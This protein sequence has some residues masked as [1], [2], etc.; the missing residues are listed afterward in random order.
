MSTI[1][2]IVTSGVTLGTITS[3]STYASPLTITSTGGVEVASGTAIYGDS[4]TAWNLV[5]YGTVSVAGS[6]GIGIVFAGSGTIANGIGGHTTALIVGGAGTYRSGVGYLGGPGGIGIFLEAGGS[7]DN[8]GTIAGGYGGTGGI[9]ENGGSGGVAIDVIGAVGEIVNSGRITGGRGGNGGSDSSG[10]GGN[11]ALGGTGIILATGGINNSASISGGAGGTGGGGFIGG[12]GG[13]GGVG[14]DLTGFGTVTNSGTISGGAFGLGG[15]GLANGTAGV[16]GTGVVLA[17]GGTVIDSGA[18][19]GGVTALYF[20]GAGGNLL[21]LEHGYSFGGAVVASGTANTLALLGTAG[22]AV[23]VLY[24]NFQA[25]NFQNVLFG[26]GG[27]AT[28]DVTNTTGTLGVTI[29]GFISNTETIDLTGLAAGTLANGGTAS[30]GQLVVSNGVQTLTL[31]LGAG[32]ATVFAAGSDG[33]VGTDIT[34]ACFLRGTLIETP[35][36]EVAVE[37]LRIGDLLTTLSGEAR[38]IRWIGHRAYDGRFIAGNRQVLPVCVKAGALAEGVPARELWLS[39]EHSL[40]VAGALAQVKH[41]VNGMTIVQADA[42]ERVEYF[43]IELDEH[44]LIVADGAP[45]ETFV[46][47][48]NRLMFENGAEY[49]ALYPD[50]ARPGWAFCLP[51]LEWGE[52]ALSEVRAALLWRAEAQGHDLD[53]DPDLR[54]VVDGAEIRPES[55]EA[56]TYRFTIPAGSREVRLASRASVPTE[57][58]ARSRDARRLGVALKRLVLSDGDLVVEA[59]HGH[60]A[61]AD[62]FHADEETARWTDGFARLP[63]MLLRPFAGAVALEVQLAARSLPYRL[64]PPADRGPATAVAA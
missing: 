13:D 56:G 21:G 48:D 49:A 40:Y 28:L 57:I 35:D 54:L 52:E 12:N 32:D 34:P 4:S 62:G 18:I 64:A 43:H 20:A 9:S 2:T 11:G 38:P 58:V 10:V 16:T 50:D 51:R 29:S 60:H 24:N 15:L 27:N 37:A 6:G 63:E 41:L 8:A 5:N 46:D 36:G 31:Q 45:A 47:C 23:S 26:P 42:V 1:G 7:V 53:S 30:G 55:S 25:S 17:V 14:V 61:L 39:P 22:N 33:S 19:S 3:G 59:R 44:D